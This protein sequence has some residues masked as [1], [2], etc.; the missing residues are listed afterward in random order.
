MLNRKIIFLSYCNIYY[1]ISVFKLNYNYVSS[2]L[3]QFLKQNA[4][5]WNG[6]WRG[7]VLIWKTQWMMVAWDCAACHSVVRKRKLRNFSQVLNIWQSKYPVS[8]LFNWYQVSLRFYLILKKQT[9]I[10]LFEIC[11]FLSIFILPF[12]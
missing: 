7:A 2:L 1:G 10:Y 12:S 3:F 9:P 8:V 11:S 4:A 6:S 5:R